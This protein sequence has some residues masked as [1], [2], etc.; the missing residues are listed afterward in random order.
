MLSMASFVIP[1]TAFGLCCTYARLLSL[2]LEE[3]RTRIEDHLILNIRP[4]SIELTA[5][6]R[7][8]LMVLERRHLLACQAIQQFNKSFGYFLALEVG[9]IFI[10]VINCSMYVLLGAMNNEG[11]SG[12]LN[13]L[14]A[15]DK[16]VRLFVL[17]SFSEDLTNE[18]FFP[19]YNFFKF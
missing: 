18:V 19:L 1:T 10:G 8:Q 12:I 14:L 5:S 16:F 13:L 2:H 9:Y 6:I 7:S 4:M 11:L 17:T 3:I 15:L